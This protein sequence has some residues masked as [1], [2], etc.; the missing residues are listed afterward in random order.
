MKVLLPLAL[1]V[2][3]IW[4]Y[5]QSLDEQGKQEILASFKKAN[6]GW[7]L[8]SLVFAVLSHLSRAY[9]WKYTLEPL[10]Y[11]PKFWNSFFAVM[12]AYLVNL[13]VPRLG[14]ISRCGVMARYEKIPFEKLLGTVIAERVADFILL[15]LS[16]L[17]VV[18]IQIDVIGSLLQEI[19]DAIVAKFSLTVVIAL[20]GIIVL[21]I[22]A[23]SAKI[24]EIVFASVPNCS[25]SIPPI[26]YCFLSVSPVM[27]PSLTV[28]PL[29]NIGLFKV[30]DTRIFSRIYPLLPNRYLELAS[31]DLIALL[32]E[33]QII[34]LFLHLV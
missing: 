12:I 8:F 25:R 14:E 17:I 18:I 24:S 6:Y 5:A 7:I 1:G 20:I 26:L 16:T 27:I 31:R 34:L 28:P 32:L 33:H 2:F 3:L 19:V 22:G 13:A 4:Y 29:L 9:R 23:N 21:G 15:L 30:L 11:K 10:G